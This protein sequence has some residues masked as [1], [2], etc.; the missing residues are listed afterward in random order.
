[1]VEAYEVLSDDS[2]REQYNQ[3]NTNFHTASEDFDY[4]EFYKKFDKAKADHLKSHYTAHQRAVNRAQKLAQKMSDE[5]FTGF[6]DSFFDDLF[7]DEGALDESGGNGSGSRAKVTH[8]EYINADG[9]KCQEIVTHDGNSVSTQHICV[10]RTKLDKL[11]ES[12]KST[13]RIDQETN[14]DDL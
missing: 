1:M 8:K 2:K 4:E 6:D 10:E 12:V 7:D 14:H 5:S 11:R 3:G 9:K 13:G